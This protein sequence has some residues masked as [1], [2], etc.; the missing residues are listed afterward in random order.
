MSS[1]KPHQWTALRKLRNGNILRA[2]VGA[3]K[4]RVAVRYYLENH[5]HQDV[6]VITTARKRDSKDWEG[7][8]ASEIVGKHADS[9][10]AGILTV[11]SWNNIDK[12]VDVRDAF[13]IF[14]EQRLV[15]TGKWVKSFLKIVKN[16]C[17]ILLTATPG[18]TW[19]D[20]IPVFIANGFYKNRTEFK[21]EH[22]IYAPHVRFPKVQRYIAEGRLIRYRNQI[23]VDMPY[24]KVTV[25]HES[26]V[27]VPH[28]EKLVEEVTKSRWHLY[29]DRPIRDIAELYSVRRR[30]I[31]SDPG[32]VEALR[33][34][35]KDWPRQVV[36]YNFDYE[37]E[38]LRGLQSVTEVSEWNGHKHEPI[39]TSPAWVYLVQYAA[40]AEAWNCVETNVITFYSLTYSY[41]MWEQ[42]HG[43]IDRLDTPFTDLHY[44]VL[45]SRS[46]WDRQIWASLNRKE[47]FNVNVAEREWLKQ[48]KNKGLPA[49]NEQKD[50][51]NARELISK[52]G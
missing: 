32:R 14:D 23:L 43:R 16:N 35:L 15:G 40:G 39:P 24:P 42:A 2:G 25:R 18:D 5:P 19:L 9:T 34:L 13:F 27:W 21:R 12:Y 45:R 6:Y 4:S 44:F 29:Y 26:T 47:S 10:I 48:A 7:E 3:G 28:N 33:K 50:F 22:V 36:F 52:R 31:N 30:V 8:F 37:L 17:W 38:L 41:K 46:Y 20:Y 1:L 49:K 11:D 51:P